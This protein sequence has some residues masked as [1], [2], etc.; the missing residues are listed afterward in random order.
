MK[1]LLAVLIFGASLT[2][3][4]AQTDAANSTSTVQVTTTNW[5]PNIELGPFMTQNNLSVQDAAAALAI[6]RA[7]GVQPSVVLTDRGSLTNSFYDL[8]PAYWISRYSSQPVSTI[9]NM[10]NSGQ[11][12]M[13]IAK[14][15]NIAHWMFNP[16]SV[17]TS[18]WT[19]ADFTNA[20]WRNMMTTQLGMT[21]S[22][23][24]SFSERKAPWNDV[25]VADVYGLETGQP[26]SDIWNTYSTNAND[27]TVVRTT[28][29][30]YIPIVQS[31]ETTLHQTETAQVTQQIQSEQ[32]VAPATRIIRVPVTHT[33][34]KTVY[35]P[36]R[37]GSRPM[38]MTHHRRHKVRR[39]K[40][41][42]CTCP[43]HK[44]MMKILRQH[45][46]WK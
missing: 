15:Y 18:A 28:Y 22:D 41:C 35:V 36:V 34:Y 6:A 46:L 3:A 29:T 42:I 33:V 26:V 43:E 39:H 45:H 44:K 2:G 40:K 31:I 20:V 21:S 10:Y 14:N 19:N 12:W 37:S 1:K 32:T 13:D 27:W 17:D 9:L 8:A 38:R 4:F 5:Y 7:T 23:F 16:D 24:T 30:K 11:T 25:V